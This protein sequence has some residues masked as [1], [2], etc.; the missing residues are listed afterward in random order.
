MCC[1]GDLVHRPSCALQRG[2]VVY[3]VG[4]N[5]GRQ[6]RSATWS[7]TVNLGCSRPGGWA[8][9]STSWLITSGGVECRVCNGVDGQPIHVV[10]GL[11]TSETWEQDGNSMRSRAFLE[12]FEGTLTVCK[13]LKLGS[14]WT[15]TR[16]KSQVRI[17]QRPPETI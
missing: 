14:V 2:N 1:L 13:L 5:S 16:W 9:S 11:S 7:C 4:V 12:V 3:A 10:M 17:L 6:R 15:F 8:G